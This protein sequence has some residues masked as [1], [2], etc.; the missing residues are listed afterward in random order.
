MKCRIM[1]LAVFFLRSFSVEV[2]K[3]NTVGEMAVAERNRRL[4][5][6]LFFLFSLLAG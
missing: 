2:A 4:T 5:I 6:L 3:A 1:N